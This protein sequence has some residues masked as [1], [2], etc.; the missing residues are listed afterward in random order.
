MNSKYS[1]LDEA[2]DAYKEQSAFEKDLI[3]LGNIYVVLSSA[4]LSGVVIKLND[5]TTKPC[6]WPGPGKCALVLSTVLFLLGIIAECSSFIRGHYVFVS[7][8]TRAGQS[9]AFRLTAAAKINYRANM[10]RRH[11]LIWGVT[12]TLAGILFAGLGL[13]LQGIGY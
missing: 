4:L 5:T 1:D 11:L 12:F 8:R 9:R 10:A 7:E 2:K 6:S 13:I 3:N